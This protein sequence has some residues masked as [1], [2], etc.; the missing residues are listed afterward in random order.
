MRYLSD[1]LHSL[2]VS[3]FHGTIEPSRLCCHMVVVFWSQLSL[4]VHLPI[5]SNILLSIP[6][7]LSGVEE[8]A[9]SIIDIMS[10]IWVSFSPPSPSSAT[11]I[12]VLS[13]LAAAANL[14]R[15]EC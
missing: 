8:E 7:L 2:R 11:L 14:V 1:Y 10:A 4:S 13:S 12:L 6:P 5:K 9:V 3:Q 15:K